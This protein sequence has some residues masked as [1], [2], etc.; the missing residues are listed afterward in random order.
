MPIAEEQQQENGC[1]S[2]L[3]EGLRLVISR[4]D[5]NLEWFLGLISMALAVLRA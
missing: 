3:S 1:L 2:F 4:E 5:A